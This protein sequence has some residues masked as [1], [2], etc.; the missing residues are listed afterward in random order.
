M[1]KKNQENRRRHERVS[2]PLGWGDADSV[3]GAQ[4]SWPNHE[5]SQIFD[6]SYQGVAVAKPSLFEGKANEEIMVTFKLGDNE[7][8]SA[9]LMVM[10]ISENAV[11]GELLNLTL[12]MREKIDD[13]LEDRL[14][15][16]H[17]RP[18]NK[19]YFAQKSDF[20]HWYHGP[21]DTNV[22]IWQERSGQ[23]SKAEIELDGR[24]LIYSDG[25]LLS[26]GGQEYSLTDAIGSGS[27]VEQDLDLS[28]N[29]GRDAPIVRRV[30]NI[31]SQIEEQKGPL[32]D[33]I[34]ALAKVN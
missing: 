14:L 1:G 20:S 25:E 28:V 3:L 24:V 23:I 32:K 33:L 5:V 22:F 2:V 12:A 6:L 8:F 4:L 27:R 31:L 15:G 7:E 11:G 13:F 16:L 30:M 17:L 34:A 18:V 26:G 21:K 19:K 29:L 10:W 9:T